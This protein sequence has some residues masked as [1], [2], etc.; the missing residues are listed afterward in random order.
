MVRVNL[1]KAG[2]MITGS[3]ELLAGYEESAGDCVWVDVSGDVV[4]DNICTLFDLHDLSLSDAQR[5]RHPP[6]AE[7]FSNY[8]YILQRGIKVFDADLTFE[9]V[10]V[11]LFIGK[12]F[13]ITLHHSNSI[14][15]NAW[16]DNPQTENYLKSGPIILASRILKTMA[17][18][19]LEVMLEFES[20]LSEIEDDLQTAMS[21]ELLMELTGY[22]TRLRRL[23]RIFS[24]HE[25]SSVALMKIYQKNQAEDE[26]IYHLQDVIDKNERLSSL[27]QMFYE[28]TGDLLDSM[29]SMASH[30]LNGTMRVLTVITAVFVPLSFIVGLY[31]MNFD[32]IP[33]LKFKYGYFM[34]VGFM[35][36]LSVSLISVFKFKKWL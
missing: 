17:S 3:Q 34:V 8:V 35:L 21:D 26:V 36:T 19:Y 9:H 7:E 13:I 23:K 30:K 15:V 6:K 1:V 11:S 29:L 14:S 12:Q 20:T 31:G 4:P 33:E 32:Y 22:R 25:K 2:K 16:W 18:R 10:Q 28:L 27:T 24:Y 5:K